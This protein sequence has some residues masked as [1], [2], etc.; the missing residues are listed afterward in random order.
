MIARNT[1]NQLR[2]NDKNAAKNMSKLSSGLRINKASDDAAGMAVSQK[3]RYQLRGLSQARSNT[4]SAISLVNTADGA[5]DE[6]TDILQ[7]MRELSVQSSSGTL[8]DEDRE[9]VQVEIDQLL[10][11]VTRISDTTEFN[12]KKLLNG[13]AEIEGLSMQIGGK[14]GQELSINISDLSASALDIDDLDVLSES[15]ASSAIEKVDHALSIVNSERAKIGAYQNRLEYT[16]NNLNVAHE[17]L[18]A[19]ESVIRD[20]DMA[21]EMVE[22]TKNSLLQES[23]T[24][25]LAQANQQPRRVIELLK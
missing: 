23:A 25:M 4:D 7:R 14:S 2:K 11:E 17:N 1:Y 20:V 10:E 16:K 22:Y 13:D 12:S 3:M 19:S 5:M 15:S 6:M 24:A 9:S 21:L 18:T 8:S